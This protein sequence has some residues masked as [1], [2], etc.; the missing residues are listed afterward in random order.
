[1]PQY[2]L[3]VEASVD[4]PVNIDLMDGRKK[5][6]FAFHLTAHRLSTDQ[7]RAEIGPDADN[8]NL[9]VGEFLHNHITGWRGQ[10]LVVDEDGKPVDFSADAFDVLLT[11]PGA[12]QLIF[13]AYQRAIQVSDGESARR[14]NS[15]G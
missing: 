7:L 3:A 8:P 14:K 5:R 4:F 2:K 12:A 9:T 6:N 1:M 11:P 13:I 15:A 10:Q